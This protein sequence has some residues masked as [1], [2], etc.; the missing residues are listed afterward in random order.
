MMI[1]PTAPALTTSPSAQDTTQTHTYPAI[2]T[3][4]GRSVTVL[5]VMEPTT[6]GAIHRA[7]DH[8]QGQAIRALRVL[9]D[10][11]FQLVQALTTRPLHGAFKVVSQEVKS[12]SLA[13]VHQPRLGRVEGK[14]TRRDVLLHLLQRT[15]G[16]GLTAAENDEIVR[17]PYHLESRLGHVLIQTI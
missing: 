16:F 9:P 12:P 11:A 1:Q 3:G 17:V 13:G 2:Q 15:L 7:D 4:E 8:H 14:S 6:Q 5:E 10:P